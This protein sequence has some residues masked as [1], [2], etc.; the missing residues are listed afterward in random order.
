MKLSLK[1]LGG[2]IIAS[3][4]FSCQN[5]DK[6]EATD[7][8]NFPNKDSELVKSQIRK[9][10]TPAFFT[11]FEKL[12]TAQPTDTDVREDGQYTAFAD[13]FIQSVRQLINTEEDKTKQYNKMVK[14]CVD[15]HQQICPGPIKKIRKLH[16]K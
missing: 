9:G 1:I 12:H 13:V 15:C 2:C 10:Q 7:T 6:K 3:S 4:F 5:T 16:I 14:R 8:I 11:E